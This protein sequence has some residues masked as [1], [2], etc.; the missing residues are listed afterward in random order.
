MPKP[1]YPIQLNLVNCTANIAREL[2]EGTYT[3]VL[4]ANKGY[5]FA[6]YGSYTDGRLATKMIY[7]SG[8]DK[9]VTT[10]T[11]VVSGTYNGNHEINMV[12]TKQVEKLA[13]FVN[14]Y[15][16]D[17]DILTRLSQVRF[18]NMG[19]RDLIDY[20]KFITNLTQI[21]FSLPIDLIVEGKNIILGNFDTRV[22]APQLKQYWYDM[23][24]G[25]IEVPQ[26]YHNFYDYINTICRLHV[27]YLNVIDLPAEYVVG[28]K[29]GIT[30][31][32]D[33]YSCEFTMNVSSSFNNGI[34]HS[35]NGRLGVN[36]PFIQKQTN[37]VINQLSPIIR[38][39]IRKPY[40]EIIRNIPY[41]VVTDFGKESLAYGKLINFS[42]YIEVENIILNTSAT[43][44]EK[45]RII[46]Q[47]KNG[48]VIR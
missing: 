1:K 29:I 41:D 44:E 7:P 36:I 37:G 2:E 32:I 13:S 34:I 16:V 26:K 8:T 4:T 38:N 40:I 14:L 22:I 42:G 23:F 25:V 47:L 18:M 15:S 12:A 9:T 17:N 39:N 19:S 35:E 5:E 30:F 24:L 10:F 33:L 6:S 46:T 43:N 27:P 21:D 48:V 3:V 31:Y 11:F 28:Y 20:G 45:N